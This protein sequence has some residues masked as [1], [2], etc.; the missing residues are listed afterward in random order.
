MKCKSAMIVNHFNKPYLALEIPEREMIDWLKVNE[1]RLPMDIDIKT[2]RKHRSKDANSYMWVL[3]DRIAEAIGITKEEVYRK[4]VRDVG[5]FDDVWIK[6]EAVET[7]CRNWEYSGV[8]WI[9]EPM[10]ERK[11]WTAVRTYYGSSTYNTKEMSRLIDSIVEEAKEWGLEVLTPDE[12]ERMKAA[13]NT[14]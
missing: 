1:T 12:L 9:A 4:H 7:F 11:G 13:W 8:G 5:V 3:A 10:Y 2:K 6:T 14:K